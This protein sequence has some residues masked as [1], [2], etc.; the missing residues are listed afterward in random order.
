MKC[1]IFQRSLSL[2]SPHEMEDWVCGRQLSALAGE[3][4]FSLPATPVMCWDP[5]KGHCLALG[6]DV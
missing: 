5:P 6:E 3:T 1:D 4:A 2:G